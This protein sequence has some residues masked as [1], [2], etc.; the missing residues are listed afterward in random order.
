MYQPGIHN[1]PKKLVLGNS[2]GMAGAIPKADIRRKTT[3]GR[4]AETVHKADR[5]KPCVRRG[6]VAG[7][8][9]IRIA[10][11]AEGG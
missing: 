2:D 3:G 5:P 9:Q 7:P 8:A 11:I 6:G 1:E 10:N 4:G